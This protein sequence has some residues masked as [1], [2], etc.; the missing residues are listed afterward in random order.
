MRSGASV[1]RQH[2]GGWKR[3]HCA[4]PGQ[5]HREPGQCTVDMH[6]GGAA[7]S[8]GHRHGK[9]DGRRQFLGDLPPRRDGARQCDSDGP[10]SRRKFQGPRGSCDYYYDDCNIRDLT[11]GGNVEFSLI[12]GTYTIALTGVAQN[13]SVAL[14][15]PR[16]VTVV[17]NVET[18]I[19]FAVTCVAMTTIRVSVSTTGP[20]ADPFYQ[21]GS[22]D[23]PL[24]PCSQPLEAGS[25]TTLPGAR[26]HIH[27][28]AH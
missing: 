4:G 28:P 13:C 19:T 10:Q 7:F 20:D 3:D 2:A 5:L 8:S 15:N 24:G 14:P 27:R 25:F 17:A 6:R 12:P 22:G 18:E 16:S 1:Q 21:V 23:C 26:R 9:S 11:V